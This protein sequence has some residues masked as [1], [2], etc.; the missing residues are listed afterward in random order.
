[1]NKVLLIKPGLS[2]NRQQFY[3]NSFR[4]EP[5]P[6]AHIAG[7]LPPET[8]IHFCDDRFEDI[9]WDMEANWVGIT[10]ETYTAKR[11]Y[12]IADA[13]R[14]RGMPVVL[15]GY[16]PTLLPEEAGQ[17]A[18]AVVVG[19][20]EN[21]M[22]AI[23]AD[24]LAGTLKPV[25]RA[26]GLHD[27]RGLKPRRDIFR[28]KPYLSLHPVEFGRGCK[29]RCDFCSINAV[30]GG[31][32]RTRPVAEVIAEVKSLPT[33]N[34]LFV[35]DNFVN[36]FRATK[37][38]LEALKPLRIRWVGQATL[39]AA[40]NPELLIL[41]RDSG[42]VGLLIGLESLREGNLRRIRK[43]AA[44]HQYDD[45]L[46]RIRAHGISVVGS[47]VFGY[48][49]DDPS[50]FQETLR[51]SRQR[52]FFT[53]GFNHL[54]PYPGTAL[55]Q[56]LKEEGRL[57]YDRW[58]LDQ[59]DYFGS[60][61]IAPRHMTPDQLAIGRFQARRAFYSWPSILRRVWDW[62]THL[63]APAH[64]LFF[65]TANLKGRR[66]PPIAEESLSLPSRLLGERG[67]GT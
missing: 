39:D 27:M 32:H 26:E 28:G 57:L 16:H 23:H 61:A 30:Y 17:H 59:E 4:L 64:L 63:R 22:A 38:L 48:D 56:R 31:S 52:K 51:Y 33:R 37:E 46:E 6:L 8:E 47:F 21:L 40:R 58:W 19:E 44:R 11:A 25:Y 1:M 62:K 24:A 34:V 54:M 35:D 65:L 2:G 43:G 67:S 15:G 5:L 20:A 3:I 55:Y 18:D 42:C 45:A 29:Y 53:A 36:S 41:L 14:L 12:A 66:H 9:P 13:F 60:P 50:S 7:L 10:V 49:E